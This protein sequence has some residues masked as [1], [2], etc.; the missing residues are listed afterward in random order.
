M[1]ILA[2]DQGTTSSRAI[3][4]DHEGNIVGFSQKEFP[5]IFPRPGWVEHNPW[6]IWNSQKE[7]MEEAINMARIDPKDI[8]AIGIT[9]QRETTI[10]WDKETGEPIYNAIVWQCRRT[11]D[12]CENLKK[13]GLEEVIKKKTGLVIDAYFSGPKITWILDNIP[14]ARKKAEE[15]K[16]LFGNVDTWLIWNLSKGKLHV[17]DYSNASR[18]MLF[19]LQSLDW[20]DELL[21]IMRVPRSMMPKPLPSSYIYGMAEVFSREIPISGDAGDQQSALFGQCAF[22]P[23]MVK[24]TYGTG[25]FILMNTG[26]RI[27]YSSHGLLTTVAYG[28]NNKVFY[29][30]EGSVFIAGAVIQW[31][32]DNLKIINDSSESEYLAEQVEDNGGIYFVPAFVGM[33]APYWDMFARGLII[34]IT[35]GTKREHIVRSALESIAYQ[36]AEVLELMEKETKIPIRNLRVD[37]GGARN[38]FLLQ[39]QADISNV[40]VERPKITE[41]T[42]L[43]SAFLAGL[44]VGFWKNQEELKEIWKSDREFLPKMDEEK[45]RELLLKWKSAVER[46]QGW[47]KI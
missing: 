22:E 19:N 33:G 47:A 34:G 18:T 4:F 9:N 37:G 11:A 1:Y 38:N 36:T 28:L 45:R 23:G 26:E 20:D 41:T 42:A 2:L 32:R 24:N 40:K 16:L 3:I 17:T 15:G 25:C 5:Q 35:R 46:A 12:F 31:L 14:T 10:V 6:D 43:G 44:A 13:E 27:H 8:S 7:V 39:F 29:A 21:E 30:L